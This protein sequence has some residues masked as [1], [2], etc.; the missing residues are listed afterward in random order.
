MADKS[1]TTVLVDKKQIEKASVQYARINE[2]IPRNAE[3]VRVALQHYIETADQ[4][5]KKAS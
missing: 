3:I 5:K 2:A 4:K 1:A